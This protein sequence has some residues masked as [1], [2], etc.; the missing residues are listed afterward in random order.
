M[1]QQL[2]VL[3]NGK[4]AQ[5]TLPSPDVEV[6]PG[7]AWGRA[8]ALFTPAYW[9]S[10]A[11]MQR[12]YGPPLSHR[13]ASSL[14]D[15]I[16][17]CLLGGYG[18]PSE[19]GLAA[20]AHVKAKGLLSS[21]CNKEAIHE[22]LREPLQVGS[23]S[24]RYRFAGQKAAYVHA[25]LAATAAESIPSHDSQVLRR[26]LLR[27]PGVGPKTAS[28]IARNWLDADDVAILDIHIVRA[29]QLMHVFKYDLRLPRDY[30][31]LE[32][33]FLEFAKAIDVRPS[34]LDAL[35]WAQM[36]IAPYIKTRAPTTP[37]PVPTKVPG[38]EKRADNHGCP[39]V[40]RR[41]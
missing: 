23:R 8:E 18:I 34:Q 33:R 16:I 4:W 30:I 5:F 19:V 20:F 13:L 7:I 2:E 26:W 11:W 22:A 32:R 31:D 38:R 41:Q 36:R 1:C 6:L 10:Q 12:Q 24:C 25:A 39:V 35:M 3:A 28:W 29:C 17:A 15:E 9:A 40:P 14:R 37:T 27:L 21:H